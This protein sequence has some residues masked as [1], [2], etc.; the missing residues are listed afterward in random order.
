MLSTVLG[1]AAAPLR[2]R[3][4]APAAGGVRLC[5]PQSKSCSSGVKLQAQRAHGRSRAR[6]QCSA[7]SENAPAAQPA[8]PAEKSKAAKQKESISQLMKDCMAGPI[9]LQGT[10]TMANRGG[11]LV[12]LR[13]DMNGFVPLSH[14]NIELPADKEAEKV[15]STM[16]GRTLDLVVLEVKVVEGRIILSEKAAV[17]SKELA[18]LDVGEVREAVVRKLVDYG[19]F[20]QLADKKGSLVSL[21]ALVHISEI[22]WKALRHPSEV[23]TVGQKVTVKVASVDKLQRRVGVSIKQL[24]SDPTKETLD[25]LLPVFASGG[26]GSEEPLAGLTALCEE[27]RTIEGVEEVTLGRQAVEQRVV[28]QDLELWMTNVPLPDGGFNLLARAGRQVQE[29]RLKTSLS[30]EAVKTIVQRVTSRIASD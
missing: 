6:L 8:A 2:P 14:L 3:T 17:A 25:T 26:T 23:L 20:V 16:V 11:L 19:A 10:V 24:E 12:R 30:K 13:D 28:S 29:V 7:T 4:A 5:S 27:L 18:T 9:L 1:V 21:E 22:A 15:L